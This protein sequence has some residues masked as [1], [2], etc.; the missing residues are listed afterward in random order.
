M[1]NKPLMNLTGWTLAFDL[2][3]TLVETAPDLLGVLNVLLAERGL[4]PVPASSA[5]HLV[6]SGVR[7]LL[8]HGFTEAGAVFD[9]AADAELMDR[10]IGLYLARIAQESRPFPNVVQIL[11]Q[12][13]HDGARLVVVTNKRTDLSLA[14]LD[15]L[16]LT[17]RFAAIVGPDVV[18]AR[19]PSGAHL[20]EAVERVGG[21]PGRCLMIGD[22][23]PDVAAARAVGAPVIVTRYG[24]TA[25]PADQ[26]GADAVIGDFAELPGVVAR[27][28]R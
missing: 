27:L 28:I 2:D 13:T 22:S 1:A 23:L 19:K 25:T 4:P 18:S 3:G 24:Y 14:L 26:L 11:D 17:R 5:R 10:F 21:D 6:G 8:E 15:A 7:A 9:A 16:D 20:R 12:F